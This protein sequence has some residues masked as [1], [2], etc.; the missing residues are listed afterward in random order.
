[1]ALGKARRREEARSVWLEIKK[2][3]VDNRTRHGV[4]RVSSS[5]KQI[6]TSL[7]RHSSALKVKIDGG[8]KKRSAI[9]LRFR[10]YRDAIGKYAEKRFA[11]EARDTLRHAA[12]ETID[13][14]DD[15]P[16]VREAVSARFYARFKPVPSDSVPQRRRLACD[17][18]GMLALTSRSPYSPIRSRPLRSVDE[19]I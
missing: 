8:K 2:K 11:T 6:A 4:K 1:M 16:R 14:D 7:E 10:V 3:R 9:F 18:N 15:S 19:I 17:A 13:D 12:G 5:H